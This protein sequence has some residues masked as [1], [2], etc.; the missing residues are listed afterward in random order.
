MRTHEAIQRLIPWYV[1]GTLNEVEMDQ[2]TEHLAT[3]EACSAMVEAEIRFARAIRSAAPA[4]LEQLPSCSVSRGRLWKT[5]HSGR[6]AR[7]HLRPVVGAWLA[8]AVVVVAVILGRPADM[9]LPDTVSPDS[10]PYRAMTTGSRHEAP[11]LQVVFTPETE[12]RSIRRI[13]RA[14]DAT[15][16]AGPTATGVY[17][18][19]LPA[20]S[21][22]GA[23]AKRLRDFAEVRWVDVETP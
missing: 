9:I 2:V 7:S 1:N 10:S 6:S 13:V 23:E 20:G 22:G 18:L 14:S 8:L 11:V 3:C 5:L 21:D 16:I 15:V 12:E 19:A 17:R 4:G